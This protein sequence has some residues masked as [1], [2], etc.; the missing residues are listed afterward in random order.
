MMGRT[1]PKLEMMFSPSKMQFAWI[2]ISAAPEVVR[3]RRAEKEHKRRTDNVDEP[4][5]DRRDVEPEDDLPVAVLPGREGLAHRPEELCQTRSVRVAGGGS[6][7][8][9]ARRERGRARRVGSCRKPRA[10]GTREREHDGHAERDPKREEQ[11]EDPD[12]HVL[13]VDLACGKG[14]EEEDERRPAAAVLLAVRGGHEEHDTPRPLEHDLGEKRDRE[15][16][17]LLALRFLDLGLVLAGDARGA[18]AV[19]VDG[20]EDVPCELTVVVAL[21]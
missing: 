4:E 16:E 11:P 13:V 15:E 10:G 18:V 6:H 19:L 3:T 20:V 7:R 12:D 17:P 5:H 8:R 1:W 2:C 21:W 9:R 14:G